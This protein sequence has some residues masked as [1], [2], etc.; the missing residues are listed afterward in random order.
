MNDIN[1]DEEQIQAL[2][3]WWSDNG[4]SL[5]LTVCVALAGITGWN[6]WQASQVA[7]LEQSFVKFNDLVNE[8]N[9]AENEGGDIRIAQA[10]YIA[11]QI[12][13]EYADSYY[14]SFAAFLKA[15]Q[16]VEDGELK[17]AEKELKWVIDQIPGEEILLV[18][19]YR[20]AKVYLEQGEYDAALSELEVADE[21]SFAMAFGELRGD[22]YM[23]QENYPQANEAYQ[24]ALAS[25]EGTELRA[26]PLLEEKI[27][28]SAS[29]L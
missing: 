27:T 21:G 12:K 16:A 24:A 5:V 25:V 19:K 1:S 13:E 11:E 2:K 23:S 26:S 22:I 4:T 10:D 20:L 28:Y 18:A 7:K 8:L 9:A 3:R 17:S 15:R 29:F 14:A 6:W